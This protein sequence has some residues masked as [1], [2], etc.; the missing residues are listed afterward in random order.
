MLFID[1]SSSQQELARLEN[2]NIFMQSLIEERDQ[3]I[4]TIQSQMV[5]VNQ[6]FVDLRNI[7]AEQREFV[8]TYLDKTLFSLLLLTT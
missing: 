5:E 2:E 1:L 6:L 7:V 4:K 3:E 8:G